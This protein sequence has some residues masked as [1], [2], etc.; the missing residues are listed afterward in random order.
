[1][2][3]VAG[4]EHKSWPLY[5][6]WRKGRRSGCVPAEPILRRSTSLFMPT[7]GPDNQKPPSGLIIPLLTAHSCP[8]LIAPRQPGMVGCGVVNARKQGDFLSSPG[9]EEAVAFAVSAV[10][11]ASI[12][13]PTPGALNRYRRQQSQRSCKENLFVPFVCL[14]ESGSRGQRGKTFL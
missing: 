6:L 14:C 5:G 13:V 1:M 3:S 12:H 11:R 9:R 2:R 4:E 7:P 8:V 10:A